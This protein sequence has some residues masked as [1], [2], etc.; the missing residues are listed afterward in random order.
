MKILVTGGSGFIGTHLVE[1][2]TRDH[3]AVQIYD[4]ATSSKYPHL[5]RLGDVRNGEDLA[6]AVA[7][8]ELFFHLAAEHRDD[9]WPLSLYTEV[10]VHG[11]EKLVEAAKKAGCKRVVFLS[12]VAVYP[13]NAGCPD[14]TS[15]PAPFNPYGAS[16]L[17]AEAVFQKWAEEDP[18]ASI[19]IVR[20]CVIFGE[21][22][23]GNVYNFLKQFSTGR[24]LMVGN[25][26]NRKSLA[27]VGNL[28]S[29]LLA[30]LQASPGLH[31]YNYA[32]KPDL[33]TN[34][35]IRIAQESFGSSGGIS[36]MRVPYLI[37]LAAGYWFDLVAAVTDRKL[38][39]S[40][41][42]IKK[43]CA[44]TTVSTAKLEREGFKRPYS[45]EEGLRRMIVSE[46][47]NDNQ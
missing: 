1:A 6:Q 19:L 25:G 2:L 39:I 24:F 27:Y 34:E 47:K 20:P 21:N 3:H 30:K 7:G 5:V 8:Q 44:E 10:N 45:L 43:F 35:L 12:S 28:V 33:S 15:A 37:G 26:Q 31:L 11:A 46:F 38:P 17:A 36:R 42:R 23:R 32:D 41:I 9:V 4:K 40:S 18:Q 13:L 29:F 16:K 22:N 14:E